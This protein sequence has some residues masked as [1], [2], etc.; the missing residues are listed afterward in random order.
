MDLTAVWSDEK[1]TVFS[2][3]RSVCVYKELKSKEQQQSHLS[4]LAA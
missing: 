1:F 2:E 4:L 3:K